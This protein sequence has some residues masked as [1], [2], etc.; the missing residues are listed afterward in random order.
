MIE[1]IP[2]SVCTP[3]LKANI[4]N[5]VR[6]NVSNVNQPSYINQYLIFN[7]Y[8]TIYPNPNNGQF[9][10]KIDKHNSGNLSI[11]LYQ[12]NGKLIF[13]QNL[14]DHKGKVSLP[15]DLSKYVKGVYYLQI[16]SDGEVV[17]KKVIYQ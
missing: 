15:I 4:D 1:V 16:V 17:T 3:S 13:S 10:L 12:I 11:N 5:S 6:S 14:P 2:P 7:S 8:F 9:K